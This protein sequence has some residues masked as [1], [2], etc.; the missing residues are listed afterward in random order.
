MTYKYVKKGMD[1]MKQRFALLLGCLMFL[2]TL[3]PLQT[4]AAEPVYHTISESDVC[5]VLIDGGDSHFIV[6]IPKEIY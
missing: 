5:D 1:I 2:S 6:T 3:T 4:F